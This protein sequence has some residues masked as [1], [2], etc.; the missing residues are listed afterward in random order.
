[1]CV[2]EPLRG[3]MYFWTKSPLKADLEIDLCNDERNLYQRDFII[4]VHDI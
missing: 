4:L 1:M 3:C 2:F